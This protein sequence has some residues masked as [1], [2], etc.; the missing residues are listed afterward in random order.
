MESAPW[1]AGDGYPEEQPTEVAGDEAADHGEGA[2]RRA[3]E[4]NAQRASG[5]GSRDADAPMTGNPANAGES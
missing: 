2:A 3:G 1:K 4:E 5:G